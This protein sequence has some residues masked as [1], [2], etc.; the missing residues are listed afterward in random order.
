V[1]EKDV[2]CCIFS[3]CFLVSFCVMHACQLILP[4]QGISLLEVKYCRTNIWS[5]QTASI[6]IQT[7]R[8]SFWR[9]QIIWRWTWATSFRWCCCL[10]CWDRPSCS[11]NRSSEQHRHW[12][13]AGNLLVVSQL[14]LV[15]DFWEMT[16]IFLPT[17][18]FQH[19]LSPFWWFLG[20]GLWNS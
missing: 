3:L 19:P 10:Q 15:D 11:Y 14:M 12:R 5:F 1:A 18:F 8:R 7:R 13:L 17:F 6:D 9:C 2:W 16:H 4:W 20:I